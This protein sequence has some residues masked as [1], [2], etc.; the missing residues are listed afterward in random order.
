MK[1]EVEGV[2]VGEVTDFRADITVPAHGLTTL[3]PIDTTVYTATMSKVMFYGD[4]SR[5]AS[6]PNRAQR[7]KR[8]A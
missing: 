3:I 5:P 6:K 4:G 7:R 1:L 2:P 8:G